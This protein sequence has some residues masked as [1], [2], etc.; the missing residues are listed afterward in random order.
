M[1]RKILEQFC[2]CYLA[3]RSSRS[4]SKQLGCFIVVTCHDNLPSTLT[5]ESQKWWG[6]NK[7]IF[8]SICL[9]D[10]TLRIKTA[11]VWRGG[12]GGSWQL[13]CPGH[14]LGGD[15]ERTWLDYWGCFRLM[16][17]HGHLCL[18]CHCGTGCRRVLLRWELG[19]PVTV[20]Y[21]SGAFPEHVTCTCQ[22]S[23]AVLFPSAAFITG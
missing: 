22:T 11:L 21:A 7:L 8:F 6:V 3:L 13:M 16:L 1:C 14:D 9:Q 20:H 15:W 18:G 19:V 12:G 23:A 2:N 4:S 10:R 5:G 17:G